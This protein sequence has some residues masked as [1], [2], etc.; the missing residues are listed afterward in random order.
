[1]EYLLKI[2]MDFLP[3]YGLCLSN[4]SHRHLLDR[5]SLA[6]HVVPALSNLQFSGLSSSDDKNSASPRLG[7][8]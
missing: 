1:M 6:R 4:T 7:L 3:K 2:L 8:K 5:F